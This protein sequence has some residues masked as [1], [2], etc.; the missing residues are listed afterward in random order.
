MREMV[1]V[2]RH[3]CLYKRVVLLAVF[4]DALVNFYQLRLFYI[5]TLTLF[6]RRMYWSELGYRPYI[7]TALLDGTNTSTLVE[8]KLKWPLALALDTPSRR[9]YWCDSK[10]RRVDSISLSGRDRQLVWKFTSRD[11]PIT[12][13]SHE[14]F[15]YVNTQS[16]TLYRLNKFGQGP[17]TALAHGLRRPVGLVVYQQQ[18]QYAPEGNVQTITG[19]TRFF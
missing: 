2:T 14:N 12:V 17:P 19:Q 8:S 15:L 3:C 11:T 1:A 6:C 10:L 4:S 7:N 16:G 18:H 13:A 9:L 5:L